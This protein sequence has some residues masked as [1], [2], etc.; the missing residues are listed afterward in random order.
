MKKATLLTILLL[1]C[2]T[3][4]V[5]IFSFKIY[6]SR[7]QVVFTEK[8]F[9]GDSSSASGLEIECSDTLSKHVFWDSTLS[10]AKGLQ[11]ETDYSFTLLQPR[12]NLTEDYEGIHLNTYYDYTNFNTNDALTSGL[13]LAYSELI[14]ETEPGQGN[15]KII[16]L[17]DYVKYYSLTLTPDFPAMNTF[18]EEELLAQKL[19][20][21]FKIP[22]LE[23]ERIE[24]S[25][26]LNRQ[27]E[28]DSCGSS[29]PDGTNYFM[30]T[31]ST[32]TDEFCFFT[33]DTHT[34][35][36]STIDLSQLPE[37]YGIYS[38]AY[39]LT[40][41]SQHD[42]ELL[43]IDIDSLKL[44]YP[45]DK[46][47]KILSWGTNESKDHLLIHALENGEYVFTAIDAKTMELVQ[48]IRFE[49]N[50]DVDDILYVHNKDGFFVT[51]HYDANQLW[52]IEEMSDGSYRLALSCEISPDEVYRTPDYDTAMAFDGERLALVDHFTWCGLHVIVYDENGLAY[53]S[54]FDV[55]FAPQENVS[56]F[57]FSSNYAKPVNVSWK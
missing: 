22:V 39:N 5:G 21:Y 46:D 23:N 48:E 2:S 37:G 30:N 52:V 3:I 55:S 45:L 17:K 43:D 35:D 20:D 36:G 11:V 7:D 6:Q 56:E 31:F 12:I 42:R 29:T 9:Y 10:F 33:F 38:I 1:L 26:S 57:G 50:K 4:S 27:G 49:L 41:D 40:K 24:I 44:C 8:V 34:Y 16:Y 53:D 19:Q 47:I 32:L 25:V 15:S 54:Q 28:L 14:Q 18:T 13:N 51:Y